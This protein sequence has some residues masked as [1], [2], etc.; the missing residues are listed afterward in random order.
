[1][2]KAPTHAVFVD[3]AFKQ[4]KDGIYLFES[5]DAAESWMEAMIRKHHADDFSESESREAVICG[6]QES[7]DMFS[8]F[9][10][11]RIR[12]VPEVKVDK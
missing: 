3:D 5:E 9:H 12:K 2:S 6:F 10:C 4:L 7:L 1:M 11:Y 8:Y